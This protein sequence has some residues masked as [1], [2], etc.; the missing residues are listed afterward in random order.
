MM[1]AYEN[2]TLVIPERYKRMSVS[3]LEMEKKKL[4]K[5]IQSSQRP[6]KVIK[7]NKNHIIFKF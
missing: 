4:L 5:E 2:D 3:E 1:A 6:R 7:E